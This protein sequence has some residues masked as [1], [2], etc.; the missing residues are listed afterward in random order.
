MLVSISNLQH[1]VHDDADAGIIM[2]AEALETDMFLKVECT[3]EM[4]G[5]Q[6]KGLKLCCIALFR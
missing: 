4:R 1:D 5:G 3:N 2:K 6:T